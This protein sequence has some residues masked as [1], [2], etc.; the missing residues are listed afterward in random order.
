MRHRSVAVALF[1]LLLAPSPAPGALM[2]LRPGDAPPAFSLPDLAGKRVGSEALAGAPA[3]VLFWSTWSPRSSEMFE[4]FKRF[5]AAYGGKG[6][7]IVAINTD[8]ES[9]GAAQREAIRAYAAARELPF[10]VLL[11][12]GLATFAAWGVMAQP[13]EVVLDAA[14][15]I[16]YVLPGYPLSLR[17]ELEEAVRATLGLPR[18]RPPET[19]P[20]VGFVPQGMALQHY[21]LGL[22]LLAKGDPE[23]A[24]RALRRAAAAD[25]GFLDAPVMIARVSLASGSLVEAE[26]LVRQLSPELVNRGDLRFLLGGMMLAKGDLDA[27]ARAFEGLRARFPREGWGEWGLAQVALARG[28]AAAALGLFRAAVALQPANPEGEASV[29][30]FFRERWLR[31]EAVP[32]EDGFVEVFPALGEVRQRYRKLYD[33][34]AAPTGGGPAAAP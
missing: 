4:D 30:R 9:L 27:A 12:E 13:T 14:G 28:D 33:A 34:V 15:R 26:Q 18:A 24:L 19:P 20:S 25:P 7:R 11:D 2:N 1:A 5:A 10:P 32:E 29:R 16:A 22:Q 21:H 31:R 23:A 3:V 6:L 8:G 17:E